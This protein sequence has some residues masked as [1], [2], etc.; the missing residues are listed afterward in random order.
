M[1]LPLIWIKVFN[2]LHPYKLMVSAFINE[3]LIPETCESVS[4]V[5]KKLE[6]RIRLDIVVST[7]LLYN[8]IAGSFG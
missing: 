3:D 1:Q 2:V 7:S 8:P 6:Q 4:E 5:V